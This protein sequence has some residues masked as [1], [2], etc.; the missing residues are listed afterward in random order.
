MVITGFTLVNRHM[1]RVRRPPNATIITIRFCAICGHWLFFFRGGIDQDE[2]VIFIGDSPL[3]VRRFSPARPPRTCGYSLSI[4]KSDAG[5]LIGDIDSQVVS[6]EPV[7]EPTVSAKRIGLPLL[8]DFDSSIF[9]GF[10]V[11]EPIHDEHFGGLVHK[12]DR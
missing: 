12:F 3:S 2:I 6:I 11:V 1:F 8:A 7:D 10:A 4:E 5:F 9:D